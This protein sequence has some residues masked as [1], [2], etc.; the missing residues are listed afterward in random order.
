MGNTLG[1]VD[2]KAV[3]KFDTFLAKYP[4]LLNKQLLSDNKLFKTYSFLVEGESN[5]I[6][7]VYIKRDNT[8]LTKH[9]LSLNYMQKIFNLNV[10]PNLLPYTKL[11]NDP[12]FFAVIRPKVNITLSHRLQTVPTLSAIE[13][14]WIV[15]QLM[16]AIYNLH[17]SGLY[18]GA[19]TSSNA[20][21]TTWDHVCL[22]DF[23]SFAPNYI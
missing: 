3:K 12:D 10:F 6:M 7:K 16:T 19:I 11:I 23:A 22:E 17:D 9:E 14:R 20:L 5:I 1:S 13:K 15:F 18:H 21:L 2:P 8:S 4:K